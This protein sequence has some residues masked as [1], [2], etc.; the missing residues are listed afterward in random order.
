[1]FEIPRLLLKDFLAMRQASQ[2]A[3]YYLFGPTSE[4]TPPCYIGQTGSAGERLKQHA[5]DASKDF[6]ITALVGVSLTNEWTS[7]HVA[8]LEWLSIDAAAKVDRYNLLN[9]NSATRPHT[10]A[11]LEADCAEF[12]ETL[13]VLLSTLG[14]PLLEAPNR[15][16]AVTNGLLADVPEVL[17]FRER[18][19][20]STGT[21]TPEGLLVHAGSTG[22]IELLGSATPALK[23][24]RVALNQEGV[25]SLAGGQLTFLKDYLFASPSAA[26]SF[27]VGGSQN[28]RTG[29]RNADGKNLHQIEAEALDAVAMTPGAV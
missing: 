12:F 23:A 26:G 9:G 21:Q 29:W 3:V 11:P 20:R 27:I 16:V 17:Y 25:I 2:V 7:T 5:K 15:P 10:P 24:R 28:G 22:R 6:W 13:S 8:L 18:G 19:C 14:Q 1:M 4:E